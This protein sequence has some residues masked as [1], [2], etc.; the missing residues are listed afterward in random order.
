MKTKFVCARSF[1]LAASQRRARVAQTRRIRRCGPTRYKDP[2]VLP[3]GGITDRGSCSCTSPACRRAAPLSLWHSAL[4]GSPDDQ[5]RL[6]RRGASRRHRVHDGRHDAP[7]R[8]GRLATA[9]HERR[10]R[11]VRDDAAYSRTRSWR[12]APRR[13]ASAAKRSA[14]R[15]TRR[16]WTTSRSTTSRALRGAWRPIVREVRPTILLV[17]SPQD[18]ME[19]HMNTARLVVTAAFV[20]GMRNFGPTPPRPPIAGEVTVYHA[21]PYGLRDALRRPVRPGVLRRHRAGPGRQAR[22]PSPATAARRSGSTSAR[23]STVTSRRWW[24]CPPAV[25]RMSG[26]FQYAEGWRATRTWASARTTSTRCGRPSPG[27]CRLRQEQDHHQGTKEHEGHE[28]E[29]S[30]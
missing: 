22:M 28:E 8:P 2:F 6:R 10:Q 26:R 11:L 16:S 23:V 18:Y 4:P 7:A 15:S 9:L 17:P 21:L 25:G 3:A 12:S 27:T 19:D 13:R 29:E 14:P 5:D 30:S 1:R 20:R 24:T